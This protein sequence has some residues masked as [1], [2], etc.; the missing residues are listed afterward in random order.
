MIAEEIEARARF[1]RKL[2]RQAG[3]LAQRYFLREL[4]FSP[5]SKGPQDWVSAADHEVEAL[6]RGEL[7]RAFPSDNMLGEED[8]GELGANTWIVDP[9]DGTINFVHGVRYWCVS[10]AFVVDGTR[11]IGVI[12]DPSLDELFWAVRG[13]GAYCGDAA[14]HA[15]ACGRVDESLLCAGYVPRHSLDG[16]QQLE[17]RLYEAGAA[18]KDMGAG[19]LMLAHV[20]AGRF[21]AFIEPHMHPWDALAGMLLVEESGGRIFPY[22]GKQ[23]LAHGGAVLAAAPGVFDELLRLARY[24]D[25]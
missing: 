4:A 2:A 11:R 9:I 21:D 13:K 20:A 23:G 7:A 17:R 22:P 5:Q 25:A 1:A 6:I 12:F 15:S 3:A 14:I 18:V 19:A 8:G 10:I 24:T 16:Y